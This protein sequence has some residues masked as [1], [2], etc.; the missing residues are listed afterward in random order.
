MEFQAIRQSPL[1]ISFNNIALNTKPLY[2]ND[3][4][5]STRLNQGSVRLDPMAIKLIKKKQVESN[6]LETCWS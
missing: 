3:V 2:I 5:L 4:I 1:L 6:S